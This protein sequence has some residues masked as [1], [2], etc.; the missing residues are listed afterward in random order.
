MLCVNGI[1]GIVLEEFMKNFVMRKKLKRLFDNF[2]FRH[3][4]DKLV[5]GDGVKRV[6]VIT[7]VIARCVT[8]L[9]PADE[10]S[11]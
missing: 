6:V 5:F 4:I 8:T 11:H 3:E 1:E 9:N 2:I 7:S 10:H